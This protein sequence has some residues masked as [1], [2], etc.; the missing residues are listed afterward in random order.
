MYFAF[1]GRHNRI[2]KS[3]GSP[4][5]LLAPVLHREVEFVKLQVALVHRFRKATEA[6]PMKDLC[7]D[8]RRDSHNHKLTDLFSHG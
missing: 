2:E 6:S 1:A 3:V 8:K 5:H 7:C 4:R